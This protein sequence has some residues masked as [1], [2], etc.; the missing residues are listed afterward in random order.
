[1]KQ[2]ILFF[3]LTQLSWCINLPQ[4]IELQPILLEEDFTSL[5]WTGDDINEDY[6]TSNLTWSTGTKNIITGAVLNTAEEY[7]AW[8]WSGKI[9]PEKN[10]VSWSW[11]EI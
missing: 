8:T 7:E 9:E 1:M 6:Q 5:T 11:S 2:I 3:I 4:D 10:D